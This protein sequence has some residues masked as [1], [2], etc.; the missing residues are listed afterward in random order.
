[1]Q[2]EVQQKRIRLEIL[3]SSCY[4]SA[5]VWRLA[6]VLKIGVASIFERRR[7]YIMLVSIFA[8]SPALAQS[9]PV[10]EGEHIRNVSRTLSIGF[11][12][13]KQ[14]FDTNFKF[15]DKSSGLSAFIDGEGTLGLPEIQ[16]VKVI[17]GYWRPSEKHGIG[18]EAFR[19]NRSTTLL[20]FDEDL[21]DLNVTGNVT[22]SDRSRFYNLTYNYTIHS[23]NRSYVFLS[24]GGYSLHLRYQLDASGSISLDGVP[25]VSG[26][27]TRPVSVFAPLPMIGFDTL[28]A[29]TPKWAVG[30]KISAVGGSY[31]DVSAVIFES[32][33]VAKYA[34]TRNFG[35][36]LGFNF[37]Q[38]EVDI[39]NEEFLT[40][41]NYGFRGLTLGFDVGF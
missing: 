7:T 22:L 1:M 27:Y 3:S 13:S 29:I 16:N 11:A 24:L 30:A 28:F 37:F 4:V 18:F 21:D 10:T 14:R 9:T 31:E 5:F 20:A 2:S 17:Y 34:F 33:I 36:T 8:S 19:I 41:V 39:D 26:E 12:A 38:G 32:R 15:T 6:L 35:L 40:E 23:D 25:I